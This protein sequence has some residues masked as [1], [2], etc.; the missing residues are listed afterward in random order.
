M[1][2]YDLAH[3]EHIC[4]RIV[5]EVSIEYDWWSIEFRYHAFLLEVAFPLY[6]LFIIERLVYG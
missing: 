3:V 4:I 5:E 2:P 6:I 1:R